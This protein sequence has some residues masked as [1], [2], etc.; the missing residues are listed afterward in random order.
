MEE[1]TMQEKMAEM[2]N[3]MREEMAPYLDELDE[4]VK[5][6]EKDNSGD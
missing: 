3:V 1:K 6:M 4:I 5:L 2:D